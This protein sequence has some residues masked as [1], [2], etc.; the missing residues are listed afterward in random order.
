MLSLDLWIQSH[1]IKKKKNDCKI[2]SLSNL[3]VWVQKNG[4]R[5][6]ANQEPRIKQKN[7][8]PKT[9]IQWKWIDKF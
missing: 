4:T 8:S 7:K 1:E 6:N 9:R 3:Q 5:R 2:I